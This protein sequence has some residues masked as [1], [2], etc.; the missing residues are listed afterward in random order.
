MSCDR[1]GEYGGRREGKERRA[2]RT[3]SRQRHPS[4][5]SSTETPDVTGP[6]MSF[7]RPA[8]WALEPDATTATYGPSAA[9][10]NRDMDPVPPHQRTWTTWNYVAYWVSDAA[11]P[12]MW[13]LASSMLAVGL[14][15]GQAL[16]AIAVGHTI[17]AVNLSLSPLPTS[18]PYQ[19]RNRAQW[20][21]RCP[22]PHLVRRPQPFILRLLA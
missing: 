13:Q 21:H 15:W 16:T 2:H 14:S 20:N 1:L 3:E 12:A 10:S 17:I 5:S 11:N 9:W 6:P 22:Y 18:C 19:G 7:L 8:T 4:A